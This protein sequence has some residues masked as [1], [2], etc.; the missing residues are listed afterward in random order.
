MPMPTLPLDDGSQIPSLAFGTGTTF[1]RHQDALTTLESVVIVGFTHFDGAQRYR[2]EATLGVA[3]K[4]SESNVP[5]SELFITTK[6]APLTPGET[7]QAAL[8]K[9]LKKLG[10]EFVD[11]YLV[12][13]PKDHIDGGGLKEVWKV[14]EECKREGLTRSIGHILEII[15]GAQVLPVINQ[16]KILPYYMWDFVKPLIAVHKEHG[17]VTSSY[18]GLLPLFRAPGGPLDPVIDKIRARLEDTRRKPVTSG[19]VLNKWLLQHDILVV[20]YDFAEGIGEYVDTCD[21]PELTAEEMGVL[22][23]K[24][25]NIEY[26]TYIFLQLRFEGLGAVLLSR[27]LYARFASRM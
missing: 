18:G 1:S 21:V 8:C 15:D 4:A 14:M 2:N 9:S 25:G 10:L 11:L 20:T 7:A 3:I 6:Y 5:R 23:R 12:R 22:I 16:L 19:Q 27:V 17:I 13:A 26:A 24:T